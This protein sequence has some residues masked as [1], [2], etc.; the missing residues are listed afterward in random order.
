MVL[1]VPE[2][3]GVVEFAAA[4]TGVE[5]PLTVVAVVC[6]GIWNKK[7]AVPQINI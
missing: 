2:P 3:P 6:L 7:K 5:E 4:V 1:V